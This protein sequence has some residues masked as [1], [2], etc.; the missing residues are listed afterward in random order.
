VT[1]TTAFVAHHDCPRHDTGWRHPEHQGRLPALVRAVYRDMLTLHGH[2]AE[3]EGTPAGEAELHLAHD[4]AYVRAIRDLSRGAAEAG[5]VLPFGEEG[6]ISGATWDAAT[7]AVGCAL[8]AVRTVRSGEVRNAFCS[9]RPPGHEAGRAAAAGHAVFN[10]VAVAARALL[11]EGLAPLVVGWGGRPG[12]GTAEILGAHPRVRL[13]SVH[14]AQPREVPWP[15]SAQ[16]VALPAGSDGALYLAAF[17]G[18]VDAALA[19]FAPDFVLLS[20]GFDALAGDPRGSLALVPE[21]YHRLTRALVERA[22]ACCRGRLVSVLEGGYEPR[23]TG[24]AVV[25]HVRALAGLPPA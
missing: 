2:L 9:V 25:Q 12:V 23:A 8:T 19:G 4:A 16:A 21:D 11:A 6:A 1:P 18:A 15:E 14:E 5:K 20:A 7:A 17:E 13:V 24:T 10:S 22:D 3:V